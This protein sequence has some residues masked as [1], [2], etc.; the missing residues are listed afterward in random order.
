MSFS[1]GDEGTFKKPRVTRGGQALGQAGGEAGESGGD[2]AQSAGSGRRRLQRE[3][4][5]EGAFSSG[6][7]KAL[8]FLANPLYIGGS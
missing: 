5:V 2:A 7:L 6:E 3:A 1:S 8:T 4:A